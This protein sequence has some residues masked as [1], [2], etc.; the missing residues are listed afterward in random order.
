MKKVNLNINLIKS[1]TIST[2]LLALILFTVQCNKVDRNQSSKQ[3]SHQPLP[4]TLKVATL[5]SP[6][7]YFIYKEEPMGYEYE[8]IKQFTKDKGIELKLII[9]QNFNSLF[10]LL[11]SNY[12]DLIAYDIPITAEYKSK[13][14][15]CG[16]EKIN[17]QVLV[18]SKNKNSTLIS[19]VT[20]LIDK[21][22]YVEKNTKYQHRIENLNK[23]LGGGVHIHPIDKDTLITEDLIRMVALNKIPLTI[24]DSDIA[25]LNRTYFKNIDISLKVSLEQRSSWGVRNNQKWLA[26]SINSWFK[27]TQKAKNYKDIHKRYFE[28]SKINERIESNKIMIGKNKISIYDNLFKKYAKEIGWDWRLLAAQAYTESGFDTTAVSWAGAKGL[29]Q[30]MPRTA[31]SFGLPIDKI[32]NPELNIKAAV[33]AIKSID[34]SLK[35]K[36]SDPTERIKFILAAYNSG[37]AHVYDAIALAAKYGKSPNIWTDNVREFILLKSRPE[38]YNDPIVKY[39][40]F[41]GNQTVEYVDKVLRVYKIYQE[42]IPK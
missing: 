42:K 17:Y 23:E 6:T 34:N 15:P 32:S 22:V 9:A 14:I 5:Y 20:E 37:I 26:D 13:I 28:I 31:T 4:D 1:L 24:V 25:Q 10:E 11:D 36:I 35:V 3:Q 2:L 12:V 40:Y 27:N 30:L 41:R 18:Q 7:S 19:D 33:K 38:Y 29:M 39:G 8:I 21:Q 16:E